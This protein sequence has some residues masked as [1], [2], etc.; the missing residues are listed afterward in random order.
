MLAHGQAESQLDIAKQ[1]LEQQDDELNAR[2]EESQANEQDVRHY[3]AANEEIRVSIPVLQSSFSEEPHWTQHSCRRCPIAEAGC[4][5]CPCCGLSEQL[6]S[7]L[8]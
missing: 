1:Q 2:G 7:F 8:C 3:K 6:W 5:F 4:S